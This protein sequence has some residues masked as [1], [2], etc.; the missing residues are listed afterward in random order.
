M[1][2]GFFSL[3]FH[4]LERLNV[5]K[6]GKVDTTEMRS[7]KPAF[8][9]QNSEIVMEETILPPHSCLFK[10]HIWLNKCV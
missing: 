10:P 1:E 5:W 2:I 7:L 9:F 4:R 8:P 3:V 6:E